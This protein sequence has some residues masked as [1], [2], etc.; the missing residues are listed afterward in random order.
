MDE[1]WRALCIV[2]H[3]MAIPRNISF[4]FQWK[5]EMNERKYKKQIV[6]LLCDN[7]W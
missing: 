3:M 2:R 4:A 5:D 7:F 1:H 6:K